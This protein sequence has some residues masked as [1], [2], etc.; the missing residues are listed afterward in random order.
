MLGIVSVEC[1]LAVLD[2]FKQKHPEAHFEVITRTAGSPLSPTWELLNTAKDEK[3]PMDEYYAAL[4][5]QFNQD[6]QARE[7][8]NY[9]IKLVKSG[10]NVFL[11]CY[12][13]DPSKCHRSYVKMLITRELK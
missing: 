5:K 4:G 2:Q 8:L 9:L 1:Y 11:V 7:R 6:I 10:K 3:W 13:K 12:E